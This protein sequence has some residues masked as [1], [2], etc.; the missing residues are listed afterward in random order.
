MKKIL[1]SAFVSCIA[2]TGFAQANK[3]VVSVEPFTGTSV[4]QTVITSVRNKVLSALQQAGRVN[5]V[6]LNN[7]AALDAE[8]ERRKNEMAMNDAGRVGDMTQLMSNGL[9]KGNIDNMTCTSKTSK[10]YDGKMHT[11]YSATLK[12]TLTLVNSEN[13][14][15]ISQKNFESYGSGNTDAEA[16]QSAVDVKVTPVKQFILNAYAVG[17]KVLA[18]DEADAKKVKTV[19][20]DLGSD[21]GL[22]KGQKL[23]VFKEVDI[24]GAKSRKLIGEIQVQEVM[25]GNRALCKVSKGGDV[26]LKELEAGTNLPIET[27]EQ[28]S[29]FFG[30]MFE[31]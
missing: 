21:D 15:V 29:S 5:V 23:E 26:I 19:Y 2:M 28:K 17:G 11:T 10:G 16:I 6:D 22:S 31:N 20:I 12:Y 9:L 7:Q 3:P 14:T 4:N 8:A 1:V 18:A 27:K 25:S 30:S 13:G 24:A